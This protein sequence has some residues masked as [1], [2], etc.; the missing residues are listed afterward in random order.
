MDFEWDP[1]KAVRNLRR[2]RVSFREA[3]T[4]FA[5]PLGITVN[6]PDHSLD[7]HGYLTV[8]VSSRGRNS[9]VAHADRGDRIGIISARILTRGER[10]AYEEEK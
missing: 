4:V 3:T 5:D 6:D 9:I 10:R 8:G 2:H 1:R 7:E